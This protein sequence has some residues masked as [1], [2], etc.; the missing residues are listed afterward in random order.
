MIALASAP[1]REL[2]SDR[3]GERYAFSAVISELLGVSSVFVH[4]DVIPPGRRASG[5]HF[6]TERD[7]IVVVLEGKISYERDGRRRTAKVGHAV[8]FPR[9]AANAHSIENRSDARARILV[10][11]NDAQG[12]VTV[13]E[14]PVRRKTKPRAR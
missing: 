8:A 13:F 1:H 6:H 5:L 12:D 4:H 7:E 10:I 11:A 3:T 2:V 9:G 14:D